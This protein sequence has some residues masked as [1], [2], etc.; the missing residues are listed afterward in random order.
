MFFITYRDYMP[1]N[2]TV[3]ELELNLEFQP[4][5]LWKMQMFMMQVSK[6]YL[7]NM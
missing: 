6:F 5:S 3:E 1:L 7:N 4:L 2:E